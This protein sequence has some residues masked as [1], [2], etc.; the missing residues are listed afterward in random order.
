MSSNCTGEIM[1]DLHSSL[2]GL[3]RPVLIEVVYLAARFLTHGLSA[4]VFR[5]QIEADSKT[6]H[7]DTSVPLVLSLMAAIQQAEGAEVAYLPMAVRAAY[8][9]ELDGAMWDEVAP[10]IDSETASETLALL[11]STP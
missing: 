2:A 1:I 10:S 8:V 11:R 3:S 5:R 4:E 6:M 7:R 9:S